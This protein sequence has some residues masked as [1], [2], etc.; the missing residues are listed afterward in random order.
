MNIAIV[1]DLDIEIEALKR[2]IEKINGYNIIWVAKNGNEAI[3]KNNQLKPD[4]ILMNLNMPICDGVQATKIIMSSNPTPII[5]ISTSV[6]LY[7]SKIFEAMGY[8][9]LDISSVPT[10]NN[11][12]KSNEPDLLK[13]IDMIAKLSG[14]HGVEIQSNSNSNNINS[15][16]TILI[17]ASTGGPKVIS[18]I[19]ESLPNQIDG[20][21]IIVQHLDKQFTQGMIEWLNNYTNVPIVVAESGL[22]LNDNIIYLVGGNEHYKINHNWQFEIVENAIGQHYVPSINIL[23]QSFADNYENT[24]LAFILTG[25]G[26]D[27]AQGLMSLKNKGWQTFAQDEYSSVVYG[28]PKA[29]YEIGAT[30]KRLSIDGII[31]ELK[32]YLNNGE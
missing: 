24:G 17:G 23:F 2:L 7:Q 22:R 4:L 10:Q 31:L 16:K 9:A 5:I 32:N 1:N 15:K 12:D 14:K 30:K 28:M 18:N 20:K 29:A 6:H 11:F 21:I 8:G 19:L 26:S 25:M 27:G 3:E 13:K